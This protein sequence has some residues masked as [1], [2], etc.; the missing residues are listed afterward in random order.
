[1]SSAPLAALS[2][3]GLDQRVDHV[4]EGDE[5]VVVGGAGDGQREVTQVVTQLLEFGEPLVADHRRHRA[6]V[7]L[8]HHLGPVGGVGHQARPP[9]RLASVTLSRSVAAIA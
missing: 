2:P 4:V 3:A 1:M 5:T 7:A 9:R 8:H 6:S